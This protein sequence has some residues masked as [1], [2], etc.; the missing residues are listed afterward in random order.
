MKALIKLL[1]SYNN[2]T[3]SHN[4]SYLQHWYG[5]MTSH[6]LDLPFS[7]LLHV[8]IISC[9]TYY[10]YSKTHAALALDRSYRQIA[11][12]KELKQMA[13]H[14][15]SY[16]ILQLHTWQ[17]PSLHVSVVETASR[18]R[19]I[20]QNHILSS[21]WWTYIPTQQSWEPWSLWNSLCLLQIPSPHLHKTQ[22]Q[23][24]SYV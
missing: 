21:S 15:D 4:T 13:L 23:C 5:N 11:Q 6:T 17:T 3:D 22:T 2:N 19:V 12:H 18:A 20:T 14:K 9:N 1:L 24:M 7:L 16:S 10:W 8:N